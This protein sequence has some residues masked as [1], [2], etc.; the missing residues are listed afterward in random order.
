MSRRWLI[1]GTVQGVGFRW[2]VLRH[3]RRLGLVGY[4]RNLPDGS[5]EVAARGAAGA[6]SEL[7]RELWRGPA[8]AAVQQVD[9]S[10][11]PH[12]MTLDKFK[13]VN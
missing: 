2:F 10:N 9:E 8:G 6:L 4:V 5:V 3:A 7:A 12:E 13:I 11:N 1:R